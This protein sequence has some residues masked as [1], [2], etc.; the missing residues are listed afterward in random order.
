MPESSDPTAARVDTLGTVFGAGA[1]ASLMFAIIDSET[2]SFAAPEVI[3]LL[4]AAVVLAVAFVLWER[5][6]A[7]PLLDLRLFRLP[8]F[9]VP[10]IV[11]FCT[12]LATFAIFFFTALYLVEVRRLR[13]QGRAGLRADDR[14]DDHRVA[15][16]RLLDR[17]GRP[18][19][20]D[21]HRLR[22][23]RGRAC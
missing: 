1:L 11:A 2:A 15:G 4:C 8:H 7:H 20:A 3:A 5:R 14:P 13:L 6:A 9:T 23:L 19:L 16:R 10:N 22:G 18:A 12:Y 21:H 17:A